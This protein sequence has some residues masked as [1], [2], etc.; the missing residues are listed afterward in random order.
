MKITK[1]TEPTSSGKWNRSLAS[2]LVFTENILFLEGEQ[3]GVPK[4]CWVFYVNILGAV[5]ENPGSLVDD[6]VGTI[7]R[8]DHVGADFPDMNVN[9]HR[10]HICRI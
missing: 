2:Y 4:V 6:P 10:S 9:I 5:L 8:E 7:H 3:D 1:A